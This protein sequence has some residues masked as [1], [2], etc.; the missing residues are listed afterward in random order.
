MHVQV[1]SEGNTSGRIS[2]HYQY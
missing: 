2:L 1:D